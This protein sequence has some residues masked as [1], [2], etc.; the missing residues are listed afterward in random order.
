M[1]QKKSAEDGMA[2]IAFGVFIAMF[3]MLWAAVAAL[4]ALVI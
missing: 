1:S 2:E 4:L 3:M